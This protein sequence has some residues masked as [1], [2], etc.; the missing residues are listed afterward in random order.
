M[1]LAMACPGEAEDGSFTQSF[2]AALAVACTAID[3]NRVFG[4]QLSLSLYVCVMGFGDDLYTVDLED[5]ADRIFEDVCRSFSRPG[6][7]THMDT[8]TPV[9]R[10]TCTQIQAHVHTCT[11]RYSHPQAPLHR[12]IAQP[13]VLWFLQRN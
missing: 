5:L 8:H 7:C 4:S 12:T 2:L 9:C 6:V 1:A 10:H 3:M 13:S 11:Y